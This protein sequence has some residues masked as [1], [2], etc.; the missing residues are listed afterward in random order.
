ME[1]VQSLLRELDANAKARV[2]ATEDIQ[3]ICRWL[4][5]DIPPDGPPSFQDDYL[6]LSFR[7]YFEYRLCQ[8]QTVNLDFL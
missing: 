3:L 5:S 1:G 7:G 8:N 6:E 2:T 4:S